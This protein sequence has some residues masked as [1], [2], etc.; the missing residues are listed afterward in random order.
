MVR[1]WRHDV[2]GGAEPGRYPG[3]EGHDGDE[4]RERAM[5]LV[6]FGCRCFEPKTN[7]EQMRELYQTQNAY[8]ETCRRRAIQEIED[9]IYRRAFSTPQGTITLGES[10]ALP[11]DTAI[12]RCEDWLVL[13]KNIAEVAA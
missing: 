3:Y 7:D 10:P 12:M 1:G 4:D 6:D 13:V 11:P 9:G 5:I 8:R 2:C